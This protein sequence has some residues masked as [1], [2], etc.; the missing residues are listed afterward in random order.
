[1]TDELLKELITEQKKTNSML[2]KI[3]NLIL[4][5]DREENDKFGREVIGENRPDLLNG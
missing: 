1:M 4:L 5:Y 2:E 3:V